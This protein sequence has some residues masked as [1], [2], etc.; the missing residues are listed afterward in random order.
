MSERPSWLAEFNLGEYLGIG[1]DSAQIGYLAGALLMALLG[2]SA[3]RRAKPAT[4][5]IPA[6]WIAVAIGLFAGAFHVAARG[7][8]DLIPDWL[9]PWAEPDR[10]SRAAAVAV[11]VVGSL[12]LLTAHWVE[13]AMARLVYRLGGLTLAGV[14]V[15]LAAGWFAD[16]M[17]EEVREWTA[18][19]VLV[20][21]GI[22]AGLVSLAV[23]FWTRQTQATP[24][25]RWF[26]RSISPLALAIAVLLALDWFGPRVFPELPISDVRSVTYILAGVSSGTF[27]LIS[28]GAYF[29]RERPAAT[30][31]ERESQRPSIISLLPSG[32]PLPVAVLLDDRGIPLVPLQEI[33]S[34]P[35]GA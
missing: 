7:F 28:G 10:L 34:G 30:M 31:V 4:G 17:P 16:D 8:S 9:R 29:I 32:R 26:N 24:H 13:G 22:I 27:L 25:V 20:R 18:R 33:Q 3:V 2:L 12:V 11:L 1:L 23:A 6:I 15:W 19:T 21:I 14:A 35:T 5:F